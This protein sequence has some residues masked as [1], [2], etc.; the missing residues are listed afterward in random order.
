MLS[1]SV[2]AW[3]KLTNVSIVFQERMK[4]KRNVEVEE[5]CGWLHWMMKFSCAWGYSENETKQALSKQITK[6]TK[7]KLALIFTNGFVTKLIHYDYDYRFT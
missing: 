7:Q 1:F 5:G 2:K 6:K 3:K 4:K